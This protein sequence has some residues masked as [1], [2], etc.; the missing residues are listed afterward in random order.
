MVNALPNNVELYENS[1]LLNWSPFKDY[2]D[3]NF[4]N[5]KVKTKKLFLPQMV[6]YNL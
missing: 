2:I 1:S 5:G 4:K 3:C 6:F